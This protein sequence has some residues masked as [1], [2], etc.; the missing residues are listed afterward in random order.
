MFKIFYSWQSDLPSNTTKQFIRD[1]IDDAIDLAS[2]CETIEAQ[3]DEATLNETG[4]PN[5]VTTIFGKIDTCDLFIADVSLCYSN[6]QKEKKAPNPNVMLELGYAAKTL[7]WERIICIC[8]SD[9]GENLPFDIAHQRTTFFSFTKKNK[10]SKRDELSKTI[11]KNI[12]DL[13]DAEPRAKQGMASH[14][15]GAYDL[16]SHQLM[17]KLIPSRLGESESYCAHRA[18]LTQKAM[19]LVNEISLISVQEDEKTNELVTFEKKD[20]TTERIAPKIDMS[21][22]ME[23]INRYY[24]INSEPVVITDQE[25]IIEYIK[26]R[27]NVEVDSSFFYL[28]NLRK[29][30]SILNYGGPTLNGT[31]DEI[32]KYNKICELKHTLYMLELRDSYLE[33]FQGVLFIP[34]AIKNVS[35]LHDTNIHVVIKVIKG[36]PIRPTKTLIPKKLEGLQG[37]LCRDDESS[38]GIIGELFGLKEDEFIHIEQGVFI[39]KMKNPILTPQGIAYAEKDEDD[40]ESELEEYIAIPAGREYY[41]FE[42]ASL[43]P[44]EI[45]WLSE[46]MLIRPC[47]G[48]IQLRYSIHSDHSDGNL[49]G[50]LTWSNQTDIM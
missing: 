21:K 34:V 13:R 49:E 30:K 6:D 4:S 41:E 48:I 31:D 37:L 47:D 8:N 18:K 45:L 16:V 35:T 9:Y 1:C 5:I 27:L 40:Y 2:K 26:S 42:V 22:A 29:N 3:R 15:V 23:A 32:N 24:A 12:R 43:R 46:G 28:G 19:G 20:N 38:E 11:F 10:D 25:R 39:P 14:I 44:K 50:L 33:S 36:E 17:S 7:G